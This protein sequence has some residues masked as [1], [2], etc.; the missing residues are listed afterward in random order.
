MGATSRAA[1][2]R[3][4]VV[5]KKL[6]GAVCLPPKAQDHTHTCTHFHPLHAQVQ[7]GLTYMD[8]TF[9]VSGLDLS[10]VWD[11]QLWLAFK[12]AVTW[13]SPEVFWN[14]LWDRISYRECV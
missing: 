12:E 7:E 2:S 13:N 14:R 10:Y 3:G 4:G 5:H 1:A 6:K 8:W 9:G 11:P